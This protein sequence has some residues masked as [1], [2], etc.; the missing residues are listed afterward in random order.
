MW[1]T[2]ITTVLNGEKLAAPRGSVIP[3]PSPLV[4]SRPVRDPIPQ[5]KHKK[6]MESEETHPKLFF[7]F[8]T[9]AYI[10]TYVPAHI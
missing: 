4:N 8:Y 6:Q 7:S 9:Y 1:H 5:N 2:F 3:Q 10:N